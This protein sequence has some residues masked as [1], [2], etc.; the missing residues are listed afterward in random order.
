MKPITKYH[1]MILVASLVALPRAALRAFCRG[2]RRMKEAQHG[3][4]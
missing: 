3:R 1:A 2:Y 4:R